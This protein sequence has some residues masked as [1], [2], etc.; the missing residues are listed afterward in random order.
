VPA[1]ASTAIRDIVTGRPRPATVLGAA[2]HAVW[3]RAGDDVVVAPTT[4]ATRLPNGIEIGRDASF[5]TFLEVE[6]GTTV[7]IGR[8]RV[9]FDALTIDAVRWWDPRP[10]LSRVSPTELA[11]RVA[12]LPS[13]P[14]AMDLSG[15][16]RSLDERSADGLVDAAS[17]LLG[18]GPGLTPEGDDYLA[19]A[20]SGLRILGDAI[21]DR[22]ARAMLTAASPRLL[23]TARRTTTTFSAA[24]ISHAARGQVAAPAA[25]L[26]RALGGRG[27]LLAAHGELTRVGHSSGPALAA[28]IVLA[29]RTIATAHVRSNGG[30][31]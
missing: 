5:G 30:T 22:S 10:A 28:G 31:T 20:I 9:V 14:S 21:G 23:S 7:T 4:D 12:E 3:V 6:H 2:T 24:L 1:V 16:I 26:F 15:L 27:D 19:G 29:A 17:E 8:N 25:S 13:T 18:R 11:T